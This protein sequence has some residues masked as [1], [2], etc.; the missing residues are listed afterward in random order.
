M[1]DRSPPRAARNVDEV[2]RALLDHNLDE[3]PIAL[4]S[5]YPK[6]TTLAPPLYFGEDEVSFNSYLFNFYSNSCNLKS[7]FQL[8]WIHHTDPSFHSFNLMEPAA[9]EDPEDDDDTEEEE[10]AEEAQQLMAHAF[11]DA[12]TM[13]QR[14]SLIGAIKKNPKLIHQIGLTPEKFPE[15]VENNHV[16]AIEVLLQLMG[17]PEI[18]EYFSVLVNME[19]SVHSMEVVN[20][21]VCVTF[22][23]LVTQIYLLLFV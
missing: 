19:V 16:V 20:R 4:R 7:G 21:S 5:H 23:S 12:L 14:A 3:V 17:S 9:V 18:T 10:E 2:I 6:F 13:S 22:L 15:L 1:L 11:K 8:A